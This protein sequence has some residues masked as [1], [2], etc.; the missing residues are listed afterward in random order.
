MAISEIEASERETNKK[1]L[2]D[3]RRLRVLLIILLVLVVVVSKKIMDFCGKFGLENL[4]C[5]ELIRLICKI[6]KSV[7]KTTY[8]QIVKVLKNKCN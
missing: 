3:E 7:L 1:T 4:L 8:F 2:H 5:H 6:K